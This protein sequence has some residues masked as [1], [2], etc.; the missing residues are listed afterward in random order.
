MNDLIKFALVGTAKAGNAVAFDPGDPAALLADSLQ[1]ADAEDRLLLHAGVT[2]MLRRAGQTPNRSR[3][4]PSPSPDDTAPT[5][6]PKLAG[7]LQTVFASDGKDLLNEFLTIMKQRG[8][9][10]PYKLLPLALQTRENALRKI[11]WPVLG[12]RGHWLASYR[13]EW[14]WGRGEA[15]SSG[16]DLETMKR[17]WEEGAILERCEVLRDLRRKDADEA[18]R[19]LEASFKRDQADHRARLLA[20][21]DY[22]LS[23]ADEPFLETC[24]DDRSGQVVQ[25]AADLL[26]K[27]PES[28]LGQRYRERA[29]AMFTGE[30]RGLLRKRLKIACSP[31]EEIDKATQRDGIPV[32]P[33]TGRGKRALWAETIL[34]RV[35]PSFW[36]EKYECGADELLAA[37]EGDRFEND[38]MIGWTRAAAHF[39][40]FDPGLEAW[41]ASL[42]NY[43][44]DKSQRSEGK[45]WMASA[46]RLSS[47]LLAM[48]R[49]S[50]EAAV[51]QLMERP[52][53]GFEGE[54]VSLL[55]GVPRLWSRSF[56]DRY[57][58]KVAA[59]LKRAADPRNYAWANTL[60]IAAI[61]I[62]RDSFPGGLAFADDLARSL[63]GQSAPFIERELEKLGEA[64]RVRMTFYDEIDKQTS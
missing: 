50:A 7:L 41:N 33:P 20:E 4:E 23:S 53:Q 48:P 27:L 49:E 21:L 63:S 64:I 36:S 24:L 17:A 46:E 26:S 47:L 42:W 18:R 12:A 32:K 1:N 3:E 35:S 28:A 10:L 6:S 5:A 58:E 61:A 2:A 51:L 16:N 43:W 38:I 54:A 25:I 30:T 22:G 45:N 39:A 15:L 31:P 56:A 40:G 57:F 44:I 8:I 19:W 13:S 9:C 55:A 62:P 60:S 59:V 37:I 29:E 34:A 11:V 14:S 52:R